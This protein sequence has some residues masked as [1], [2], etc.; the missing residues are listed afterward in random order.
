M[1]REGWHGRGEGQGARYVTAGL[2]S[3]HTDK[4]SARPAPKMHKKAAACETI[5][6]SDDNKPGLAG[7]V[8]STSSPCVT[9]YL[10]ECW[11]TSLFPES[12]TFFQT[13]W[14]LSM[15][16]HQFTLSTLVTRPLIVLAGH[17]LI[18]VSIQPSLPDR[19]VITLLLRQYPWTR[20]LLRCS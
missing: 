1:Q 6:V 7:H 18:P 10:G 2:R 15:T 16:E 11:Y 5:K 4:S 17:P 20:F 13:P 12:L 3:M 14:S 19:D 8:A 9:I